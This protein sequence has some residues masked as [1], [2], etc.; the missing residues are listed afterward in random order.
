MHFIFFKK[1]KKG[2]SSKENIHSDNL[3]H[4][5][6][7]SLSSGITVMDP[8]RVSVDPS[9]LPNSFFRVWKLKNPVSC[10]HHKNG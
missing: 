5:S 9:I 2:N 6:P 7:Q 8:Y 4:L 3:L 10:V 1:E